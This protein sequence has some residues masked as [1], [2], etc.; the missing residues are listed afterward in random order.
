MHAQSPWNVLRVAVSQTGLSQHLKV[1]V[2]VC[3]KHVC[4][5]FIAQNL[6]C[7]YD[8]CSLLSMVYCNN[9]EECFWVT[10]VCPF[11]R[12]AIKIQGNTWLS[13]QNLF[14]QSTDFAYRPLYNLAHFHT[15]SRF[16]HCDNFEPAV[17]RPAVTSYSSDITACSNWL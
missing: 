11:N 15:H 17:N 16:A 1:I 9:D 6:V 2:Q 13:I 10:R 14:P 3:W 4:H 7:H 5:D 8:F 12:N